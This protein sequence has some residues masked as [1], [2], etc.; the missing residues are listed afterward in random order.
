MKKVV[1]PN[2]GAADALPDPFAGQGGSYT[3]DPVTG[4]RRLVERT[5]DDNHQAPAVP[6]EEGI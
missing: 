4:V 2:A 1:E 5:Q 6:A 3:A